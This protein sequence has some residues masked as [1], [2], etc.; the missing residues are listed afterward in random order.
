MTMTDTISD[1]LT[2]VRN[3]L[4]AKKADVSLPYSRFKHNLAKV[5][6]EEGWIKRVEVK[7]EAG[8]KTLTIELKY[9][10]TGDSVITGIKRVSK[11]GQRIYSKH[12]NL[13]RVMGS[14]GTT[15]VST[16]KGLMTDKTARKTQVGGEIV[17]Q[18]W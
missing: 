16:S 2:R 11:P 8:L 4:Q 17:C 9:T 12:D 13:P 6:Q 1:M 18:I 5:I 3:A 15:I 7:E 14:M 10:P